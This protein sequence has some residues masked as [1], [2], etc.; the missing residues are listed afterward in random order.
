MTPSTLTTDQLSLF[1]VV[2]GLIGLSS[3]VALVFTGIQTF[4][5]RPP[6]EAEYATKAEVREMHDSRVS[7]TD[8]NLKMAA[9]KSRE[10]LDVLYLTRMEWDNFEREFRRSEAHAETF[11]TLFNRKL[12]R[13]GKLLVALA[14]KQGIEITEEAE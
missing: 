8:C 11:R 14:V 1:L 3:L 2:N 9:V 5:R 6:I 7:Q 12:D 4:R 13:Q 10:A